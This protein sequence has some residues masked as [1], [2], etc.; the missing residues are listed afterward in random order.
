MVLPVATQRWPAPRS[1]VWLHFR[2]DSHLPARIPGHALGVLP[3]SKRNHEYLTLRK[4]TIEVAGKIALFN[5]HEK[6]P[7]TLYPGYRYPPR[8][9]F[10]GISLDRLGKLS[11]HR[12]H[13]VEE[14]MSTILLGSPYPRFALTLRWNHK[15]GRR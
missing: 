15:A 11:K 7:E 6:I 1:Y 12:C 8:L 14:A 10:E 4:D 9:H 5:E 3:R 13:V 2:V